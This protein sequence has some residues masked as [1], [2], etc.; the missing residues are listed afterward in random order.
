MAS[1]LAT[2]VDGVA[3]IGALTAG[4]TIKKN[5]RRLMRAA[6]DAG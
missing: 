6:E 4:G 5:C 1:V 3:L 2:G